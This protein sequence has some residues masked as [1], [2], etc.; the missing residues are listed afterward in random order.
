M[1]EISIS[2]EARWV[3][4]LLHS[5]E[6][7]GATFTNSRQAWMAM[8][9]LNSLQ[10]SHG[11]MVLSAC[12]AIPGLRRSS[13]QLLSKSHPHSS[14]SHPGRDL[15]TNIVTWCVAA[16]FPRPAL[17]LSSSTKPFAAGIFERTLAERSQ[18]GPF[19]M[20]TGK[21]RSMTPAVLHYLSMHLQAILRGIM[22]LAP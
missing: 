7:M 9:Q 8:I 6:R 2:R 22:D 5:Q 21:T 18:N 16:V 4:L 17:R 11:A 20:H 1:K 10:P 3:C 15:R 12:V 19:L 14:A 13:G